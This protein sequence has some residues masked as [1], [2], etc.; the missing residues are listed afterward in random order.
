MSARAAAAVIF[1]AALVTVPLPLLG[2][3]GSFVPAARFG[4]LAGVVVAL[5]VEEGAGGMVGALA[6]L[7]IA[8]AVVYAVL[9]AA[10]S[11]ALARFVLAHLTPV[12]RAAAAVLVA[13]VLLGVASFAPIYDTQFHHS[14][15]HARLG[16]LY[17]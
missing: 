7:L 9:L 15:P 11:W 2:L 16:E 6:F 8:H 14:E 12:L 1:V 10:A 3:A 13:A 4:Q 17:R 5:I